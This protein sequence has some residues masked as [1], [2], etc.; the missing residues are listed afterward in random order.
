MRAADAILDRN[1]L[2]LTA[3]EHLTTRSAIEGTLISVAPGSGKSSG[4]GRQLAYGLLS[5]PKM[6]G[7]VLTAKAEETENWIRYARDCGR[8]KDL[9]IFNA[10]SGDVFDPLFYEWTRP[11]RGAGYLES[12]IDF[13]S[14]LISV[15]KKE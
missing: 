8:S 5:V 9:I 14:T 4:S 11:G 13:F 1:I 6:G 7:L 10:Q 3:V 15:G 12:V 2:S